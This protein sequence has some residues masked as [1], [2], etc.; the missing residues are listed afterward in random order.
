MTRLSYST[1]GD[2][3][4]LAILFLHGFMGSA[5]DWSE[6]MA[7]LENRF[8]CIAADLPGHGGSLGLPYPDFYTMDGAVKGLLDLLDGMGVP[9]AVVVGYS[10]GGRLALY[11]ALRHPERCTGLFLESAS[12][13]L[14]TEKERTARRALDEERA[15]RLDSEGL[16]EF[17]EDWYRQPLFATL[18]RDR[19]LLRQTVEARR[20]N[21]PV[22]LAKSLRAMGTGNQPSLWAELPGLRVPTLAVAGEEDTKFVALAREMSYTSTNLQ[23]CAVLGAGHSVHTETTD[24]YLGLLKTLLEGKVS[25]VDYLGTRII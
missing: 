21:D 7:V 1:A 17:L 23:A 14:R 5:G 6:V 19:D 15:A 16:E 11:L 9:R 24:L 3:R 18:A 12:P 13:G 10:M 22:E 2:D 20:E 25:L 8:Y 4:N